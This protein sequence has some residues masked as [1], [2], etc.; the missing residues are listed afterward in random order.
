MAKRYLVL[1]NLNKLADDPDR[2]PAGVLIDGDNLE[3]WG[4]FKTYLLRGGGF[5]ASYAKLFVEA[6]EA[7][8]A[9]SDLSQVMSYQDMPNKKESLLL[10]FEAEEEEMSAIRDLVPK[11]E[12]VRLKNPYGRDN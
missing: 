2:Y 5:N 11:A 3:V 9:L 4:I 10:E 12:R 7:E 1:E 8:W 6:R